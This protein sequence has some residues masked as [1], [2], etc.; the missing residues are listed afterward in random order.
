MCIRDRVGGDATPTTDESTLDVLRRDIKSASTNPL[1]GRLWGAS[2]ALAAKSS[3]YLLT[4]PIHAIV[5]GGGGGGGGGSNADAVHLLG[6]IR[7]LVAAKKNQGRGAGGGGAASSSSPV[8]LTG[9]IAVS[10]ALDSDRRAS[11]FM[12][13]TVSDV[14]RTLSSSPTMR[15]AFD[16][17][18][19]LSAELTSDIFTTD[20][21][22]TSPTSAFL[23]THSLVAKYGVIPVSYTHLTL[24]TKRIV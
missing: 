17:T 2:S 23:C 13:G 15:D 19:Q 10:I 4:L 9:R 11:S 22:S 20:I 5:V 6:S 3:L 18:T 12:F 7:T 14:V 1:S 16:S 21:P 24:P 8:V